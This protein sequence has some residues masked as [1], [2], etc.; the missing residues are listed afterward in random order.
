MDDAKMAGAELDWLAWGITFY[1]GI[2]MVSNVP[3]SAAKT[4]IF[5]AVFPS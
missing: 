1:A 3:F 4:S 2:T 5:A